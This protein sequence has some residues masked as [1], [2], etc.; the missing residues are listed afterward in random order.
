MSTFLVPNGSGKTTL[1]RFLATFLAPS[2]GRAEVCGYDVEEESGEAAKR[3]TYI[4]SL[5][6][7]YAWAD[8]RVSVRRNIEVMCRLF[9]F[10]LTGG[11]WDGGEA[12]LG[13]V[14]R[15]PFRLSV[16]G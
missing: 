4:P 9:S 6:G 7:A 12:G 10:P 16:Y 14:A 15:P 11:S 13:R 5:L 2:C 3:I 1:I 8:P